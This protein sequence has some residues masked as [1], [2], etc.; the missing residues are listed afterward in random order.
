VAYI[1]PIPHAHSLGNHIHNES[2]PGENPRKIETAA[3]GA[4]L[5][6]FAAVVWFD[7][8]KLFRTVQSLPHS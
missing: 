2:A 3:T 6:Y 5:Q 8:Q 7:A 1:P 4:I